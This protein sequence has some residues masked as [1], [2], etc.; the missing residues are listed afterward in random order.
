M[1]S[2][3]DGADEY[4]NSVDQL[5]N[6]H[7]LRRCKASRYTL[8]DALYLYFTVNRKVWAQICVA[9]RERNVPLK[10]KV[11]D[12]RKEDDAAILDYAETDP[13]LAS[14]Q[15]F[16]ASFS[17]LFGYPIIVF[18]AEQVPQNIVIIPETNVGEWKKDNDVGHGGEKN[19][20]ATQMIPL[21]YFRGRD[22]DSFDE[23]RWLVCEKESPLNLGRHV[24]DYEAEREQ[25]ECVICRDR[26][27]NVQLFP[28]GHRVVCGACFRS[29]NVGICPVCRSCC[30]KVRFCG[31]RE[32]RPLIWI[33]FDG[34]NTPQHSFSLVP[35]RTPTQ[36]N[37]L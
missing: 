34:S 24:A 13:H 26:N 10:T 32:R 7:G 1:T 23:K 14:A 33:I 21:V 3:A 31:R 6:E 29:G 27:A 25:D 35:Y 16:L 22:C 2:T 30:T 9:C 17:A 18:T 15:S 37:S 20:K 8:S 36:I 19:V 5:L 28:C 4:L 12:A 11:G